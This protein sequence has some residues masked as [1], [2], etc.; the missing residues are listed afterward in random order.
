MKHIRKFNEN[1]NYD[2][3]IKS[4]FNADHFDW[5]DE[6]EEITI[7]IESDMTSELMEIIRPFYEQ[8]GAEMTKK[9]LSSISDFFDDELLLKDYY[10][11]PN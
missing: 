2:E 9:Y 1:D 8:N 10:S 3:D 5:S 11:S 4:E 6:D 7:D